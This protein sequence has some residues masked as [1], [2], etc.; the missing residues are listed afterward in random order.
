[1]KISIKS[2]VFKRFHPDLKIAFIL[3][4]EMNNKKKVHESK[5]L[6]K[7]I[8]N[9]TRLSFH[10][11]TPESH[12]FI[13]PWT[14]AKLDFGEK[15]KHYDTSLEKLLKKVLRN[16][17]T[18]KSDVLTNILNL[19]SLK[20]MV[21][22]GTDNFQKI[23]GDMIFDVVKSGKKKG[24]LR[25]LH[26]GDLYY[27]DKQGILGTK[28][29][30]WKNRRTNVT[31]TTKSAL[32]HFERLPPVTRKKMNEILEETINLIESFCEAKT[33]LFILDKNQNSLEI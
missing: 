12:D 5:H 26:K 2:D 29:D 18:G 14:L 20:H 23:E 30:S 9:L 24:M 22:F 1:M 33:K 21:P 8:E 31:G 11:N 10:K 7:E 4:S 32:I 15:A 28:L 17:T 25:K 27:Q 3:V 19:I 13:V 6:L 16:R